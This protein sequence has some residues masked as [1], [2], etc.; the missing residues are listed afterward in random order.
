MN[1]NWQQTEWE[2][3][4]WIVQMLT[5]KRKERTERTDRDVLKNW[6]VN[7]TS[8]PNDMIWIIEHNKKHSCVPM[9]C[10]A[11]YA[12]WNT[13]T[14][15]PALSLLTH[16]FI[17]AFVFGRLAVPYMHKH[18]QTC[19]RTWRGNR[20]NDNNIVH[21]RVCYGC[22]VCCSMHLLLLK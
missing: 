15:A 18:T 11:I 9:C 16:L 17:R 4:N 1:S 5:D 13:H 22:V 12:H 19:V 14:P 2:K 3:C 6:N 8:E 10:E 7:R 21:G 20:A